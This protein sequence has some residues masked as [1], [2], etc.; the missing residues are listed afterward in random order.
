MSKL[1]LVV[2]NLEAKAGRGAPLKLTLQVDASSH[3][4][5]Q[6]PRRAQAYTDT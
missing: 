5:R 3:G 1:T 4:G 6:L 2:P